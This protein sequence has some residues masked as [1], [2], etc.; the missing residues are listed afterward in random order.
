MNHKTLNF[1]EHLNQFCSKSQSKTLKWYRSGL[2]LLAPKYTVS[3]NI[4]PAPGLRRQRPPAPHAPPTVPRVVTGRWTPPRAR[5]PTGP[6]APACPLAP[7]SSVS[8]PPVPTVLTGTAHP[9][10]GLD[11]SLPLPMCVGAG[12]GS[13]S[14]RLVGSAGSVRVRGPRL[15]PRPRRWDGTPRTRG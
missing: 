8:L 13:P 4:S 1:N 6:G 12:R 3:L 9:S 5:S 15:T 14:P 10:R 11:R 2:S 7:P